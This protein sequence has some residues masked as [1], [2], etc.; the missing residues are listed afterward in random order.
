M[1]D[2]HSLGELQLAIMRVLW[3]TGG[4]TSTEVHRALGRDLAPTTVATMLRKMEDK[5]VVEH[6]VDGRR[7]V[8]RAAVQEQAITRNMVGQLVDR[9]F[10]GDPVALVD[11][12]VREGEIESDRLDALRDAV[13]RAERARSAAKGG[14]TGKERSR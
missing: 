8:Y 13:E 6:D 10:A 5:G 4:A 11:H 1:T 14:T 12:L 3:E 7:F 2:R 9:L